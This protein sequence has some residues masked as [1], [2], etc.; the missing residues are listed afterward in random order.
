M[1]SGSDASQSILLTPRQMAAADQAAID[2]GAR[3]VDLMEAAGKAVAETVTRQW[4]VG[5]VCVL[6]GPGIR[7]GDGF[8]AARYL[9]ELGR[10][11]R[12]GLS[13]GLDSLT[14]HAA[15]H[16]RL[17]ARWVDPPSVPFVH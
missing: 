15:H 12:V 1:S 4:P 3:G 6:C 8:L 13:G 7:G 11:V 5:T 2:A 17:C 9:R 10:T 14:P 16:A